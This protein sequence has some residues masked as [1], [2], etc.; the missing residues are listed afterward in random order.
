MFNPERRVSSC[1]IK[2]DLFDLIHGTKA[3]PGCQFVLEGLDAFRRPL[4]QGFHP[5]II[6][7]LHKA[8]YLMPG[9]RTLSKEAKAHAL[10]IAG[11]EKL[12]RDSIR[13]RF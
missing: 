8:D 13:H 1:G 11:D 3:R 9:R 7:V 10:N 2:I 12:S 6:E 4:S 5:P